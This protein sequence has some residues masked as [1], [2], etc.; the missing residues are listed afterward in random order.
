MPSQRRVRELSP[1]DASAYTGTM[2]AS[3][4]N[5][6]SD[7]QLLYEYLG[8]RLQSG[9]ASLPGPEVL[10]DLAAYQDQLLRLR[11]MIREGELSLDAGDGRELDIDAL[12]GRVRQRLVSN[13]LDT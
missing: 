1:V 3:I 7:A 6:P 12:L 11:T 2:P 9:E 5:L 13:G 4:P 10:A 8:R